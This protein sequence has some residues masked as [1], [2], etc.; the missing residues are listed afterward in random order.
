VGVWATGC[1]RPL[2]G[3]RGRDIY[4]FDPATRKFSVITSD[5]KSV[6]AVTNG[7]YIAWIEDVN[8]PASGPSAGLIYL[9]DLKTGRRIHLGGRGL[10]MAN[11][12]FGRKNGQWDKCASHLGMTSALVYWITSAGH[13][14]AMN[15]A[16]KTI[17]R[18]HVAP[19][20]LPGPSQFGQGDRY[21][22]SWAVQ[23][24]TASPGRI[25]SWV[26]L[27]NIR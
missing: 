11:S 2:S 6:D 16:R 8:P 27:A 20:K 23:N 15:L 4:R 3:P 13:A 1:H 19:S 10:G 26:A 5:H 17:Y 9:L 7:H 21:H 12:C 18:L 25:H 24:Y 22:M 14:V